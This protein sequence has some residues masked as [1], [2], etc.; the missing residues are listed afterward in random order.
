MVDIPFTE[1][2]SAIPGADPLIDAANV[3]RGFF[4]ETYAAYPKGIIPSLDTPA[5]RVVDGFLRRA[6]APTGNLPPDA[7]QPPS[8]GQCPNVMYGVSIT[9][10]SVEFPETTTTINA[11]G[12][13]GP[14]VETTT[15]DGSF[16]RFTVTFSSGSGT[17][18][19]IQG[20]T[21]PG[22]GR[23]N[24][25]TRLDGMPDDCGSLP[26]D[27]PNIQP[28][29]GSYNGTRE[30]PVG[31]NN[32]T[33]PVAIVPVVFSPVTIL[34]PE[35]S[36]DV[37]GVNFNF[38]LGGVSIKPSVN[39]N[40]PI[41]IPGT[42]PGPVIPPSLPPDG[43]GNNEGIDL[44]EINEKLNALLDCDRCEE[45]FSIQQTVYPSATG[46]IVSIP[47]T[48]VQVDVDLDYISP[49]IDVQYGVGGPNVLMVGWY[50]F[51]TADGWSDRRPLSYEQNC[52]Y[53][54]E[55]ANKFSYTLKRG[56]TAT[57]NVVYKVSN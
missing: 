9:Y 3:A 40:V 28:P 4:C 49:S 2:N 16:T 55:G 10:K 37:G 18:T 48:T 14:A 26:P 31:G 35:F 7:E 20:A 13:I 32:V 54:P 38:S 50:A 24:S 19:I 27:Y 29:S 22:F 41:T 11:M 42:H 33:V 45:S 12:P 30:I 57:T 21:K 1:L 25:I 43:N 51:G 34:K 8:G 23:I 15:Q 5:S 6:C 46:R 39:V 52:L 47:V 44:S 36:V 53:P 56:C 17:K